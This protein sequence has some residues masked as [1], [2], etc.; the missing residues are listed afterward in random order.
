[1][2][3]AKWRKISLGPNELIQ[4]LV[5]TMGLYTYGWEVHS[6]PCCLEMNH[7]TKIVLSFAIKTGYLAPDSI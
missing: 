6:C 4:Y 5:K 3:L 7:M 2:S 1:M